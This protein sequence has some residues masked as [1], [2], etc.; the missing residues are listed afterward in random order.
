MCRVG[1]THFTCDPFG[2]DAS[3]IDG[4]AASIPPYQKKLLLVGFLHRE[5]ELDLLACQL[6]VHRRICVHLV[7]HVGRLL[8]VQVHFDHLGSVQAV[9]RV[10]SDNLG[11]MN[12]TEQRAGKK[13]VRRHRKCQARL[14]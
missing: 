5:L 9:A 14:I 8:G 13:S 7:L 1:A 10:L 11:R 2:P 12:L 3:R 6:L 4:T